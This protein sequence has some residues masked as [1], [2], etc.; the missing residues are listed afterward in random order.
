MT[1]LLK[2]SIITACYNSVSTISET[3]DSI[4]SQDYKNIEL[5]VID[6]GSNDGTLEII[7]NNMDIISKFISEA[8]SG[9]YNAMNKGLKIAT[10]DIIGFLNSD[11]T[12]FNHKVLSDIANTFSS[13]IDCT[14]GNLVFVNSRNKVIRRWYSNDF[15][16]G[17]FKYSWT[18]AHPTFYCKKQVYNRLGYYREDFSIASDV[19]LMFRFLEIHR[20]KSSFIE[21]PLVKM[22]IGGASTKSLKSTIR[23]TREV[24]TSFKENG[25]NYNYLDYLIGKLSKAIKQ[26]K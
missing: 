24:F 21:K 15:E 10:G 14:F 13:N 4:R 18:P 9:I 26:L 17:L 8:D 25:Y 19:D 23:I 5:I 1:N 2:I 6:G 22:K 7:G 20:I 3:F 16:P 12:Y 11:D